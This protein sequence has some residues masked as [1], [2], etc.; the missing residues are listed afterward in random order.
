MVR[1]WIRSHG[2]ELRHRNIAANAHGEDSDALVTI[3]LGLVGGVGGVVGAAVRQHH[4][5][6]YYVGAVSVGSGEHVGPGVAQGPACQQGQWSVRNSS[7]VLGF[8]RPLN[9]TR[10]PEDEPY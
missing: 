7:F 6:V 8:Q 10:S 5:H 1:V 9:H 4:Q 2:I 3:G